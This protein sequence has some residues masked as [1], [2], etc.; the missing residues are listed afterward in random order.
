MP[1]H[2]TNQWGLDKWQLNGLEQERC[3]SIAN[4]LELSFLHQPIV[5]IPG[6]INWAKLLSNFKLCRIRIIHNSHA[7]QNVFATVGYTCS[8]AII[9]IPMLSFQNFWGYYDKKN[10][11]PLVCDDAIWCNRMWSTLVQ[12]MAWCRITSANVNQIQWSVPVE[13]TWG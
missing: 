7:S 4:A 10:L 13:F 5:L 2:Y 3:N 11:T 6:N 12:V 1:S 8:Y 9:S